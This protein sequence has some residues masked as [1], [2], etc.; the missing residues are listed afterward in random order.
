MPIDAT[1]DHVA[2]AVPSID[3]AAAR[4]RDQLGGVWVNPRMTLDAAGFATRQ[5]SYPGGAKLE[6]LEPTDDEGFAAGFVARYGARI[7]HVTLKV[8]ELLPAVEIVRAEGYDVIDVNTDD[9]VWHE[10]FLRPSQVGGMIVQI[11]WAGRTDAEWAAMFD[12]QPEV[13]DDNAM[14]LHG[15]TLAHPDLDAA[16]RLWTTLGG[17]V[18]DDGDALQ[19]SWGDAALTVRI[20]PGVT[21][22]PL[23]LRCW[24]AEAADAD[25]RTGPAILPV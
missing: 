24:G 25:R 23:G 4:W 8:A 16:R 14:V 6:L 2:I 19:V 13:A 12:M 17:D 10:A 5:L 3:E 9:A 21:P 15:P 7:H 20:V 1:P 18:V 11:A 22:G